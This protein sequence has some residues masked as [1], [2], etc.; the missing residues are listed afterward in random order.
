MR[1]VGEVAVKIT[2]QIIV[3]GCNM[4]NICDDPIPDDEIDLEQLGPP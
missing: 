3:D 2:S 1:F 4:T